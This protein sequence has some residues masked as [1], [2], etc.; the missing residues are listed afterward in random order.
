MKRLALGTIALAMAVEFSGCA[1]NN[2][3][4]KK[5][6]PKLENESSVKYLTTIELKKLYTGYTAY[7][8]NLKFKKEMIITYSADGTFKG[9]FAD[10]KKKASGNWLIENNRR[11]RIN[12]GKWC[13]KVYKDKDSYIE[14]KNGNKIFKIKFK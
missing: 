13:A 9:I 12:K 3:I 11:C 2:K 4:N 8:Q 7:G 6:Y 1:S 10:G 5:S 14:V